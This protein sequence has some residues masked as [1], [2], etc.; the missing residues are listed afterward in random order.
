MRKN[1]YAHFIT[2]YSEPNL[3]IIYIKYPHSGTVFQIIFDDLQFSFYLI[4]ARYYP[5]SSFSH[6]VDIAKMDIC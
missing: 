4:I 6:I 5:T 1:V 3:P 2:I